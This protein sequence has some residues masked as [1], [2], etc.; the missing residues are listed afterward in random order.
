MGE[1]LVIR[2]ISPKN[3][4]TYVRLNS[5]YRVKIAPLHGELTLLV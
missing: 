3:H 1:L 4:N 2:Y 5:K